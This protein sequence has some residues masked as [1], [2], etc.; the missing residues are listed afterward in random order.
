MEFNYIAKTE[1]GEIVKGTVEAGSEEAAV[2]VLHQKNLVILNLERKDK[3]II[4]K[5]KEIK[6]GSKNEK[7]FITFLRS[8]ATLFSAGVPLVETLKVLTD[9]L[10][11]GKLKDLMEKVINDVNAGIPFSTAIDGHPDIF[12]PLYVRMIESAEVSGRLVETLEYI[13]SHSERQYEISSKIKGALMYPI[14]LI[15]AA[16]VVAFLMMIYVIPQLTSILK[17]SGADIPLPTK[18]LI[19]VSDFMVNWWWL[20]LL[21]IFGGLFAIFRYFQ[22]VNGLRYR[23]RIMLKLPIF[24]QFFQF[25][26]LSRF[27]ENLSQLIQSGIPIIQSLDIVSKIIGNTTYVNI[28]EEIRERV[29]NGGAVSESLEKYPEQFPVIVRQLVAVG[30]KT[31]KMDYVLNVIAKFYNKELERMTNN[32]TQLIEPILI[33]VMGIVVGGLV[34]AVLLP[35]YN[36]GSGSF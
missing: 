17:E 5:L 2:E 31:G 10:K 8:V 33:V 9:K 27:A 24:G 3:S 22:G 25:V 14:L 15:I 26:Y 18:I 13:A 23:D 4:A 12:S 29:K 7:E 6:I 16:F 32:M 20:I 11:S 34:A 1:S 36:I 35:I 21:V 28:L 30:E 19:V